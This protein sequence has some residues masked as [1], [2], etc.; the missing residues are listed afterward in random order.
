MAVAEVSRSAT[1]VGN[2]GRYRSVAKG[3]T[4]ESSASVTSRVPVMVR[5]PAGRVGASRAVVTH[6]LQMVIK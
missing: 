1:I 4:A 5:S 6:I 2:A 3:A